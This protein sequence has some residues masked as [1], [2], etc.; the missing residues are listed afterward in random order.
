ML[1]ILL[2]WI[3]IFFTTANL[4][5]IGIKFFR[6]KTRD[7]VITHFFGLFFVTL[8][9]GF[10]AIF[11]RINWEFHIALLL[12]N[13]GVVMCYLTEI[14]SFYK[15]FSNQL[16]HLKKS[17]KILLLVIS[18][19]IIAQCATAPF[20]VDNESYYIQS[21]KWLNEY[22]LIKGVAN[23]HIFLGQTSGWHLTQSAFNFSFLYGKFNDLSGLCL[24]LGNIFALFKFDNYLKTGHR[25]DLFFGL[26]PI[27]N[28]LLFQFISAPSPD[29]PVYIL[30]FLIFSAWFEKSDA[31]SVAIIT[32]F[33]LFTVLIK[34]TSVVILALPFLLLC[35]HFRMV[36]SN[37]GRLFL[38]GLAVL[39]LFIVKNTIVSGYPLFPV[40]TPF[41]A[42][43][44]AV[45]QTI[46][47]FYFEQ[48]QLAA[49]HLTIE[50]FNSM[51]TPQLFWHW[52]TR[53]KL[54]GFFNLTFIILIVVSPFLI[55]RFFNILK[56][57]ILYLIMFSGFLLLF[58]SSPQY[59]F[60]LHWI[61]FFGF[62]CVSA[63]GLSKKSWNGL[64][65]FT[66]L[67]VFLQL[68]FPVNTENFTT[69]K[70]LTNSGRFGFSALIFPY[71][72]SK[73]DTAFEIIRKGNLKYHSPV[74]NDFFWGSGDGELPCVNKLQIE[75]FERY[76][77]IIP[78]LR[79]KE[80]NGGFY[81]KPITNVEN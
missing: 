71:G 59:R 58:F 44:F 78:Q 67:L 46:S 8:L 47:K 21:I 29:I 69:N 74:K 28:V 4:G 65:F 30:S 17:S 1:L 50:Q 81:S 40:T 15:S 57:W 66:T 20:V 33:A 38:T 68:V 54:H 80:L 72:N 9:A 23:L 36:Y 64:L 25:E 62:V 31:D 52:L 48:T 24:L 3:Y 73:N 18:L 10:W 56:M 43:D 77:N 14:I 42:F 61:L 45:P 19:L 34:T 39:I 41:F 79:G 13:L 49:F 27:A 55:Y 60:F 75:Y 51:T 32:V 26:L 53:P 22:G 6:V 76:Y 7:F 37:I 70:L 63:I 11:S 2:S 16:S 5:V 12:L 35:Q